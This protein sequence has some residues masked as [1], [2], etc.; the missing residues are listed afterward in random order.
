MAL[1]VKS[2]QMSRKQVLEALSFE[3]TRPPAKAGQRLINERQL[4]TCLGANRMT[5]RRSLDDLEQQGL[6]IRRQG[7]GT[8]LRKVPTQ[9]PLPQDYSPMADSIFVIDQM[10]DQ[11]SRLQPDPAKQQLTL[12]LWGDMHCTSPANELLLEGITQQ[13]S[14]L[15]HRLQTYHLEYEAD[16]FTPIQN[17]AEELKATPCDGYIVT[18]YLMD[19]FLEA[20]YQVWHQSSPPVV[21]V[22]PG[23]VLPTYEPLIQTDTQQAI[24][25]ATRLLI[26]QGYQQ[27]TLLDFKS[28]QG[29]IPRAALGYQLAMEAAKLPLQRAVGLQGN[30]P[31]SYQWKPVLEKILDTKH[32]PEAICMASEEPLPLLYELMRQRDLKPGRDLGMI[33]IANQGI[34]LP[35]GEDWSAMVFDQHLVGSMAVSSLVDVISTAGQKLN[36]FSHQAHWYPGTTHLRH[37]D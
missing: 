19:M 15:S 25:R 36:S 18:S 29:L 9:A 35:Q 33:T 31:L 12:G 37:R 27:I 4:A 28:A 6:L 3:L 5:V 24:E 22:W 16:G 30:I 7:S 14:K 13:T 21:H 23:T 8:Y 26:E 11:L 34:D 20:Y 1:D 10:D 2:K 17:I 32:R